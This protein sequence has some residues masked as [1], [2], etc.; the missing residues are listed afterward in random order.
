MSSGG[1]GGPDPSPGTGGCGRLSFQTT[2]TSVQAG[3][4]AGL[5]EGDV[6]AVVLH[7]TA[8]AR[9]I[10]VLTPAGDVLGAIVDRWAELADCLEAGYDYTATLLT[11]RPPV[12]AAISPA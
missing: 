2:V 7:G 5:A 9:Q 1:Y 3:V 4:L 10:R 8:P 11:A 12:R 6:C